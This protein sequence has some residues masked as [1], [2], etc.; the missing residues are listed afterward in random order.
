MTPRQ[1]A[2]EDGRKTYTSSKPCRRGHTGLRA[3]VNGAC[4]ECARENS[5]T[6]QGRD[7][8]KRFRERHREA[9]KEK[10]LV[11]NLSEERREKIRA[12]SKEYYQRTK[13]DPDRMAARTRVSRNRLAKK[14]GAFGKES[15]IARD[16]C[17]ELQE[18]LCR[19]C[20]RP[21]TKGF[22]LD[23]IVPLSKRG[24]NLL[25][26]FQC[27]CPFCNVSKKDKCPVEWAYEI[28]RHDLLAEFRDIASFHEKLNGA[29][30]G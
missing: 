8:Q 4:Y 3:V 27:L 24:S 1:K 6:D 28:N 10:S 23:H 12:Y 11:K 19:S 9:I 15:R 18:G 22:H 5:K 2:R 14:A 30:S 20:N 7:R 26:N 17:Y 16:L 21:L 13:H 25:M 29:F